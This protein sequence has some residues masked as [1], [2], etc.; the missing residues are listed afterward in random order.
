LVQ[1]GAGD[2]IFIADTMLHETPM[3]CA[4]K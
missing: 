1:C 3:C 2:D 4:V